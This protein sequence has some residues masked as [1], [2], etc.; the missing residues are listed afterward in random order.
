M[1]ASGWTYFVPYQ[2]DAEQ[3]LRQLRSDVFARRAYSLP[4]DILKS[5]RRE[6]IAALGPS[7]P[8]L[9]KMLAMSKALNQAMK[10]IGADTADADREARKMERFFRKVEKG[11]GAAKPAEEAL[12]ASKSAPASI[13]TALELAGE[14]GTHSIL[15]IE[16][17][18]SAAGFGLATPL[19]RDELLRLF[20]TETPS[21][22]DARRLEKTGELC[23]LRQRW[24]AAYFTAFDGGKPSAIVFCGN[25]G[26]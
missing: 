17:T 25:S 1:G 2:D 11:V 9:T 15:D 13:E 8:K 12:G 21:V 4:G 7:L 16:R 23:S 18:S 10:D 19:T 3:A 24:E 5:G 22:E 20:G 14:M 26:D 6:A